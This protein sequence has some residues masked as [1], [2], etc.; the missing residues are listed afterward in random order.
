MKIIVSIAM[1]GRSA[2]TWYA[3]ETARR[4][5][6]RGHTVL[7]LPRPRDQTIDLARA[8]GLSVIDDLDLEEKS[9]K[10]LYGNLRR[11][12]RIIG[13]FG[14]DVVLAHW[15]EDHAFW[16]LAKVVA[17]RKMAVIRVRAL[18]PKPP[19][20][21][22]LSLWL[23]R[24]ATDMVVTVNT[25]LAAAYR[26]RL[27]IPEAKLRIIPAGID[28]S[29][30]EREGGGTD[31]LAALGVPADRRVVLLLARFSPVKGHRVMLSAIPQIR[32]QHPD[33]HFLWLGYPSEY[34]ADTYRRWFV[35]AN[36]VGCVTVVERMIPN[37]PAVISLCA[38]G[39]VSSI[40]SE[41]VSRSLFEY[42]QCGIPVVATDV[43]GVSDLME[44]GDFGR[45]VPPDDAHA[46]AEAIS[47]L[48]DRPEESARQGERARDHVLQCC[49][50][51]QRVDE[52]E[53]V[54]Y[55][56]VARVRGASL[57][58]LH[59]GEPPSTGAGAPS[60]LESQSRQ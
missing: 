25:R 24:Q 60:L 15:G 2:G 40:G 35:E 33:T 43:G 4:F 51:E 30:T 23:H 28:P 10:T 17:A 20:R 16:G 19:K 32:R 48:L 47:G 44:Q 27:R 55:K 59:D 58:Q 49:T 1:N 18:D 21:H 8:A 9:P 41:S 5:Q 53:D 6:E 34:T 3:I 26:I 42:M 29:W 13:E 46:L 36:Q 56:V 45:L 11:L 50:W 39:V 31:H 38:V 37:L 22:P 54:L 57:P 12:I 14:P 52:W 7:F